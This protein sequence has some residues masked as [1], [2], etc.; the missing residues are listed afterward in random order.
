MWGPWYCLLFL[1]DLARF[2]VALTAPDTDSL[3]CRHYRMIAIQALVNIAVVT[4]S[5]PVT[6]IPAS[7]QRRRRFGGFHLMDV[8]ILLNISRHCRQ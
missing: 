2:K 4:G 8:G 3:L 6:G 7:N 1:S 5:L